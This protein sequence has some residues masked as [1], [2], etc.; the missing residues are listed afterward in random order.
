MPD[1][2]S[3][4]ADDVGTKLWRFARFLMTGRAEEASLRDQLEEALDEADGDA[5]D[6]LSATERTMM[7]NLLHF[8]ERTVA[9]VAVPRADIVAFDGAG[10]FKSL[11]ALFAEVGHS[12]VPVFR[13]A[14]DRVVGMIHVK[15]V[16]AQLAAH[17][18]HAEVAPDSL[19]RDVLY[20]P[21]SMGVLDLLARMRQART[22][23]AIVIDEFGGTDG[24]V[25]IEDLVEEIVGDIEDEHDETAEGL[26]ALGDDLYEADARLELEEL[27]AALGVTLGD[28]DEEEV[29]TVGGLVFL[30]AGRVPEHGESFAHPSGWR[31]E[32]VEADARK[33]GRIRIHPPEPQ[34]AEAAAE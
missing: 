17:G 14:L 12:R 15:D 2:S 24:L 13:D 6:D 5:Q 22:H 20:V 23:M 29:D 28:P 18:R 31:F 19:L 11:V 16:Y 7:R 1:P 33:I 21:G 4:S 9:D 3:S 10:D 34:L 32:V 30:L 26:T 8:G 27:E 25:T